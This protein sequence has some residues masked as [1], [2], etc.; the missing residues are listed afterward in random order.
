MTDTQQ[1][2]P[3]VAVFDFDGTLTYWDTLLFFVVHAF[4]IVKTAA[5]LLTLAPAFIQYVCGC[6]SRQ[7][8][9]EKVI[10]KFFKGMPLADVQKLGKAFAEGPLNRHLRQQS[11]YRIQWH[12]NQGHRC[13]LVSA[14]LNV[15]LH[16]WALSAGFQDAVTSMLAVDNH[17][18][19]TGRLEGK[20]CWGEEKARRLNALLGPRENYILYVYGDS[21]GDRELL[22]MADYAFYRRLE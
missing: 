4:G 1:S 19:I 21:R 13:I 7:Q 17:N 20:N 18:C 15:Y 16:P 6:L 9:K 14:S 8:M 5:G 10:A 12:I 11:L 3:I 22:S 2:K